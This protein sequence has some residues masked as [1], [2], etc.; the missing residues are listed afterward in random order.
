MGLL[1]LNKLPSEKDIQIT[2]P[3]FQ[4][5]DSTM[6][7]LSDRLNSVGE[8][9]EIDLRNIIF[10]SYYLFL[11]DMYLRNEIQREAI[12]NVFTNKKFLNAMIY[13][14]TDKIQLSGVQAICCNKVCWDA[15]FTTLDN[16]IKNLLLD[17]SFQINRPI[18]NSLMVYLNAHMSTL[19]SLA[20]RS[21]FDARKNVKRVNRI[22]TNVND[23]QTIVNVYSV[24]FRD[25]LT[26]LFESTMFD[27]TEINKDTE[28]GWNLIFFSVLS[29][30]ENVPSKT[31]ETVLTSYTQTF[32]LMG[33]PYYR[34]SLRNAHIR[35][36]FPRV[37]AVIDI[38]ERE[39]IIVP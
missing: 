39:N 4:N 10:S 30:M 29:I 33:S 36:A 3:K 15:M 13:C 35:N 8:L 14:V 5:V 12:I 27:T 37:S 22:L 19:I 20:S 9:S 23:A 1:D 2:V 18:I 17:L 28:A 38:L 21:S 32:N 31:I 11:D 26:N 7:E 6:K 25:C 24:L 34:F 16:E